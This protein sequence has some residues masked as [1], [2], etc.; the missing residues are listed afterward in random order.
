[1]SQASHPNTFT[2]P[3]GAF[4]EN[5]DEILREI[6]FQATLSCTEGVSVIKRSDPDCLYRLKRHLRPPDKSPEE[7][8]YVFEIE[9]GRSAPAADLPNRFIVKTLTV[10]APRII[11]VSL[12]AWTIEN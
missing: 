8:F 10:T 9:D 11:S 12:T 5:T 6:G 4:S 7:F 1:M 2:Y 3:F